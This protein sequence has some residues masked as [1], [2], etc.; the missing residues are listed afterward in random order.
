MK[1]LQPDPACGSGHGSTEGPGLLGWEVGEEVLQ[2]TPVSFHFCSGFFFSFF[3]PLTL[4]FLALFQKSLPGAE[5]YRRHFSTETAAVSDTADPG[6]PP[7]APPS[8]PQP[9]QPGGGSPR[10]G[11][12]GGGG[13][14][15][16]PGRA[17][18]THARC[19]LRHGGAQ[20]GAEAEAG[21]GGRRHPRGPGAGCGGAGGQRGRVAAVAGHFLAD[22]HR[23]AAIHSPALL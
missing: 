11:G 18:L 2:P 5:P 22:P 9:S 23:A 20:R 21:G 14:E 19:G 16:G 10:R 1:G 7:T 13:G 8:P 12:S 3:F 6:Q 15:G 4:H 17:G